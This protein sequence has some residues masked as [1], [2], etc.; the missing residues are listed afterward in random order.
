MPE[1]NNEYLE[2]LQRRLQRGGAVSESEVHTVLA[3]SRILA[4]TLG[5][6]QDKL[7]AFRQAPILSHDNTGTAVLTFQSGDI[8]HDL[9]IILDYMPR[10]PR[11]ETKPQAVVIYSR[12][13][14]VFLRHF[15]TLDN[16]APTY[17]WDVYGDDFVSLEAA[18]RALITAPEPRPASVRFEF[19][20]NKGLE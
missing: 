11:P 15:D 16:P 20:L 1:V 8:S 12:G 3:Y 2:G 17:R 18:Q 9:A 14:D 4:Q 19:P 7:A 5:E 10:Y 13:S 6:V